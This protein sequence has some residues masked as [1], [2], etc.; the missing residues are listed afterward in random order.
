[1]DEDGQ[2][3]EDRFRPL[4][5]VSR[6]RLIAAILLGPVLWAVA[7]AFIARIVEYTDAILLGLIVAAASFVVSIVV[8]SLLRQ[9]RLR[10]ERRFAGRS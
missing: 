7:L 3:F 1:M 2:G 9:G 8:L 5:P 6:P 4:R 10:E